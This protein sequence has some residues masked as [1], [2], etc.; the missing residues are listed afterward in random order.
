M[1]GLLEMAG[2]KKSYDSRPALAIKELA[3]ERGS[4]TA[5]VG[6]NGSGKT[7]LMETLAGLLPP[8][9]GAVRV[10]GK[11]IYATRGSARDARRRITLTFQR[12]VLFR[13]TVFDNVAYP[14]KVRRTWGGLSSPPINGSLERLPH[15]GE[16]VEE[17]VADALDAIGLAGFE[18][19]RH[20]S[21]SG[22]EVQRV[23]IARALAARPEVLLLDEPTASVGREFLPFLMKLITGLAR[24]K[25]VTV[26]FT[27]H[28]LG[29]AIEY[30]DRVWSMFNGRIIRGTTEN[31]FTV[32]FHE[33]AGALVACIR[34][35]VEIELVNKQRVEDA[36]CISILAEKVRI[37]E[38]GHMGRNV[39]SGTLIALFLEK[40]TVKATVDIGVRLTAFIP[41]TALADN[42]LA[43]GRTVSV[44]VPDD[45]IE[46]LA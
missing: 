34:G 43:L 13:G 9:E 20:S 25:G 1:D 39:F 6:P 11:E 32:D 4:V 46:V 19:R 36:R 10:N 35:G 38:A 12:P 24:E 23:A 22:G 44:I 37:A 18:E 28:H 7:T 26:A 27:T 2:V 33:K 5:F 45:A 21:L 8:D 42:A 14:L 41:R 16:R 3:I 31:L 30:S 15:S 29:L 17:A 40:E